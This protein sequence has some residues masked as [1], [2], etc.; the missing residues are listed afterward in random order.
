MNVQHRE[1]REIFELLSQTEWGP[2]GGVF[3]WIN[4]LDHNGNAVVRDSRGEQRLIL[5]EKLRPCSTD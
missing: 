3:E 5:G 4:G 1:T 2:E